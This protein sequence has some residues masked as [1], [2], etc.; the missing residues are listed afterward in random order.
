M[1]KRWIIISD[2]E[3]GCEAACRRWGVPRLIAQLLL[4][5]GMSPDDLVEPFLNPRMADLHPPALLLGASAAAQ[6]IEQAILK[7]EKI[8]LY[9]DYDVDGTT[10]VAILWH[11]LMHAGA[12]VHYYVPHRIDEGYGL[13]PEAVKKLIAILQAVVKV[14]GM[15]GRRQVFATLPHGLQKR[16]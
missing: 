11:L 15:D 3:N 13:N 5:R 8:V 4:N 2:G 12:N 6:R 10:G 9:G 14:H 1:S 7:K 16:S